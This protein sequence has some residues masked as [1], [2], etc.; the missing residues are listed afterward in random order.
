MVTH[1][2]YRT[3]QK[4]WVP[5]SDVVIEGHGGARLAR[6]RQTGEAIEI[7]GIEKMSKSKKN[8]VDPDEIIASHGADT[9]RF[10][11]LSDTPPERDI[12]WSEAGVDGAYRFLQRLWRLLQE[13]APGLPPAGA[14]R[15]PAFQ[16]AAQPCARPPIA[17]SVM[18]DMP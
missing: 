9:A 14:S 15:P 4:V 7:V 6:H 3:M 17:P 10:F 18:C 16:S 11:M 12:A 2:A 8:I 13:L 1:E 5:P